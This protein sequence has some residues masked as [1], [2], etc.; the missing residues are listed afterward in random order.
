MTEGARGGPC[1]GLGVV[2]GG[3]AHHVLERRLGTPVAFETV[4]ASYRDER[5]GD[6]ARDRVEDLEL[7]TEAVSTRR[8]LDV[9]N[10][11][12][13]GA[14]AERHD[15]GLTGLRV[16]PA[17][18]VVVD[19]TQQD[20]P[21]TPACDPPGDAL[22]HSLL[23]AKRHPDPDRGPDAKAVALDEHDRRPARADA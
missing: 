21:L 6:V 13:L 7:L 1:G 15:H 5:P 17:E 11:D 20:H 10:A 12:D 18:P 4:D 8:A 23:M 2:R 22:V 19:R 14:G 9:E 3:M 16:A